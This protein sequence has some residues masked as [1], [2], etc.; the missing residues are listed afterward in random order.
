[1]KLLRTFAL[2]AAFL[3]VS[4]GIASARL[5]RTWPY[6]ELLDKS[7]L[8]V[9]ATP[10]ASGD[11]KE[12]VPLPGY[13][14]QPVIGVETKFEV[15]AVLKG[16]KALRNLVLH[17]YR[18]DAIS[19]DNGPTL[20]SFNP[21]EKRIF[22]LYLVREPDG[23]YAPAFGQVDPGLCGIHVLGRAGE[24]EPTGAPHESRVN[25]PQSAPYEIVLNG[26]NVVFDK[27]E[28]VSSR[29]IIRNLGLKK[30]LAPD[31]YWGLAVVWDGKEYKRD[32]KRI[33]MWDGHGEIFPKGVFSTGFSLSEYLVPTEV[34]TAGGHTIA[35]KDAS[36]ESNTLTVFIEPKNL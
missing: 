14:I 8:V 25:R 26:E 20:V 28:S 31:L 10:T 36:A 32:P 27:A 16:E 12:H 33:G 13:T 4:T 34:L 3:L 9:I 6:Q 19:V 24:D 5:V 35:L 21:A 29:I 17:H 1:M 11:T 18:A 30:M 2:T 22:L 23:R 7:D 15:S